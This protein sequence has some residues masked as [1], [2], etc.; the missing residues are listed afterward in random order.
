M[1]VVKPA[2]GASLARALGRHDIVLMN[3]HGVT[4]VGTSVKMC[5]FRSVFS[6]RNAEY[7]VRAMALGKIDALR[8]G[9]VELAGQIASGTT[10]L[11]RSWE[12][13]VRRLDRAGLMPA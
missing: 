11:D 12:Y 10:G 1:L 5:V 4:A 13:W 8:P 2:E 9:E 6:A 3:R 7:Q